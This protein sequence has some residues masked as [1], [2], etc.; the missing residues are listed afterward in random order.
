M[1]LIEKAGGATMGVIVIIVCAY[2]YSYIATEKP[3]TGFEWLFAAGLIP[4]FYIMF[5]CLMAP[6]KEE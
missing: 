5:Y 1:K 4:G 6:I 2:L 3:G